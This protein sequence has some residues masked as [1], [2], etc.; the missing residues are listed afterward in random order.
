M[1]HI[2][3]KPEVSISFAFQAAKFKQ[4][5]FQECFE[6][7]FLGSMVPGFKVK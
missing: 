2:A 5:L 4:L 7:G 3:R 6:V 1:T